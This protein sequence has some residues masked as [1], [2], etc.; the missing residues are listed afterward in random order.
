MDNS[1]FW[2]GYECAYALAKKKGMH[3][4]LDLLAATKHDEYCRIDYTLIKEL[5]IYTVREGMAWNQID[6][7]NNTYNFDRFEKMMQVAAEENIKQV[8]NLNH[9]D[10]PEYLDPFSEKF[11]AQFAEYARRCITLI[12]KYQKGTL[13]INPINEIS[14]FAFFSA[15]AGQWAPFQINK[16]SEFKR[17]L[18]R[19]TLTA[20]DAMRAEDSDVKFILI[21]PLMYRATNSPDAKLQAFVKNFNNNIRFQAWDMINGTVEPELGGDPSYIDIIGINYYA[22]NQEWIYGFHKTNPS[23]TYHKIIPL[24]SKARISVKQLL[25]ETFERYKKPIVIT[26]T[27]SYGILRKRWWRLFLKEIDECR[28]AAV[29]LQIGRAHV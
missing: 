10:F 25:T 4:R 19:A 6:K 28:D 29:P 13:Y 14:F 21:D 12:R 17:Q 2:A 26:E 15:S 5:G 3:K 22:H 24:Q 11:V 9:F 7:G 23:L 1:F 20:I 27:G 16:G 8:W 18:V